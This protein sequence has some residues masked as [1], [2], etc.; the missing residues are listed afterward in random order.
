MKRKGHDKASNSFEYLAAQ[1]IDEDKSVD[2]IADPDVLRDINEKMELP[3]MADAD[4]SDDTVYMVLVVVLVVV[5][6]GAG[7]YL[8]GR[9]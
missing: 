8:I 7:G 4:N 6:V 5:L 2:A 3:T 9:K 1:L